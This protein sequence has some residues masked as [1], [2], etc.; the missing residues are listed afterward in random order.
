MIYYDLIIQVITMP[1]VTFID[2]QLDWRKDTLYD[3]LYVY[4]NV[5]YYY[6]DFFND[7]SIRQIVAEISENLLGEVK[8]DIPIYP[9]LEDVFRAFIFPKPSVVIL[10]MDPYHN[11]S[12]NDPWIPGSA[13]GLAFS[14]LNPD[15][16]NPSLK[17]IQSELKA[18]GFEVNERSGNLSKWCEGGVML[19]NTALTVREKSPGKHLKWW[20]EFSRRFVS[21]LSQKHEL[22]WMLWG[23]PAQGMEKHIARPELQRIVKTSHPCPLSCRKSCGNSP[24]FTGSGCFV[25]ANERLEELGKSTIDWNL[26]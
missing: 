7:D 20:S 25:E 1:S 14:V 8:E 4:G 16:I 9:L 17:S 24:P 5:P 15:N 2:R 6:R 22:V 23:G 13:M 3:F 26:K 19:L 10:G 21:Y 12:E 18:E 11:A